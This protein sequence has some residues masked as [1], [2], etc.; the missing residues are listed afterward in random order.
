MSWVK[1]YL[2]RRAVTSPPTQSRSYLCRDSLRSEDFSKTELVYYK[3]S[4]LFGAI[5]S[6][7]FL[8]S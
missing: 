7:V 4:S 6:Y 8:V 1:A 3:T 5:S 2:N